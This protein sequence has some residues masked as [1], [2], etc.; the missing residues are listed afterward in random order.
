MGAPVVGRQEG[1]HG[2]ATPTIAGSNVKCIPFKA[3]GF[4][5]F[6]FW[7]LLPFPWIRPLRSPLHLIKWNAWHKQCL[8]FL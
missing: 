5:G 7:G 2:G 4:V 3:Q 6:G 1:R 8:A